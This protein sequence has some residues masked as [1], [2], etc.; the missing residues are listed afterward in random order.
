MRGNFAAMKF[1][2]QTAGRFRPTRK[3][4]VRLRVVPALSSVRIRRS[5]VLIR[6]GIKRSLNPAMNAIN[7][8]T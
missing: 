4:Y 2:G 3:S 5:A 1:P 6:S 7:R 8:K